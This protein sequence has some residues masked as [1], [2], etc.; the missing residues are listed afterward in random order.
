MCDLMAIVWFTDYISTFS[1]QLHPSSLPQ[2][3]ITVAMSEPSQPFLMARLGLH[4]AKA[5]TLVEY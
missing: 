5:Y 3:K 2:V 1:Y 4:T